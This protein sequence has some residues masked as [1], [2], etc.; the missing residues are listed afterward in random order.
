MQSRA[1]NGL[2]RLLNDTIALCN[3]ICGERL[4]YAS[5]S[6]GLTFLTLTGCGVNRQRQA[7]VAAP[8]AR[9]F[10]PTSSEGLNFIPRVPQTY[11]AMSTTISRT[12]PDFIAIKSGTY[13][14]KF[15]GLS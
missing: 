15:F 5:K 6:G 1:G 7:L 10:P 11:P 13:R 14:D 8:V 4:L 12:F 9:I 2:T 3:A